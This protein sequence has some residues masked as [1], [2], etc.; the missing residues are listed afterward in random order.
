MQLGAY[1]KSKKLKPAEF[2]EIVGVHR[3]TVVRLCEGT[4]GVSREMAQRI[5]AATNGK[6]TATD[7]FSAKPISEAKSA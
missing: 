5:H 4:R 1:L 7:L 3:T 2:A 6:V